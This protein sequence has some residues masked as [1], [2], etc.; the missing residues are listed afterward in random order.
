M[1]S[2]PNLIGIS[3]KIGTG[4]DTVAT[5]IN[6]ICRYPD[7]SNSTI[8]HFYTNNNEFIAKMWEIKKFAGKMK[9]IASILTGIPEYKF[10]D[11]EFKKELLGPEWGKVNK[12]VPLN[13][14]TP[15]EDIEF[16][17]LMSVREFLQKLG[18]EAMRDG[19]HNNTWIN[20]LFTTYTDSAK[21]IITDVRFHNEAEA[22]KSRGGL[23]IRMVRDNA[24][25]KLNHAS[26][27][28]LDDF[29]FDVYL[30]NDGSLADLIQKIKKLVNTYKLNKLEDE[31][32]SHYEGFFF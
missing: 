9:S 4:K 2:P 29:K 16:N 19:L 25:V 10:E 24:E 22:I 3:G 31:Y 11:Q 12:N 20:A 23:L 8:E 15:S 18:T 30:V 32:Q 26:E 5:L 7:F 6:I 28:S 21:W 17:N 13:S 14:I 1:T 27:T